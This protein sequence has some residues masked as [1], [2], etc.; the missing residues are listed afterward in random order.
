M[1][2]MTFKKFAND[3]SVI[4]CDKLHAVWSTLFLLRAACDRKPPPDI[5]ARL[6]GILTMLEE[7]RHDSGM[8]FMVDG[9]TPVESKDGKGIHIVASICL[10]KSSP[11]AAIET[12]TVT[13]EDIARV[14]EESLA[15]R[16]S[17][18]A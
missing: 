13:E 10:D 7:I 2:S 17:S 18:V 4:E 16:K 11:V 1:D 5:E 12:Y 9:E 15:E 3:L 14:R 6:G 8:P